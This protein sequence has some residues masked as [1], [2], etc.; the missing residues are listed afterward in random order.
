VCRL[1]L[2]VNNQ[3]ARFLVSI[4]TS[5]S[6][7]NA[8][9]EKMQL[10]QFL[11]SV[12]MSMCRVAGRF[13]FIF[14]RQLTIFFIFCCL[15]NQDATDQSIVNLETSQNRQ[16]VMVGQAMTWDFLHWPATITLAQSQQCL[17][18]FFL[19]SFSGM[20]NSQ[21]ETYNMYCSDLF[22]DELEGTLPS[23][24]LS[25]TQLTWLALGRNR[26]EGSVPP[27]PSSL[28]TLYLGDNR[29]SGQLPSLP[30]R[31][32][33]LRCANNALLGT[34]PPLP[35][36]LTDL[37]LHNNR[38]VGALHWATSPPSFDQWYS[39]CHTC[40]ATFCAVM[41]NSRFCSFLYN[42]TGNCFV[43]RAHDSNRLASGNA[44]DNCINRPMQ[45]VRHVPL[46]A[47]DRRAARLATS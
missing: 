42:T 44:Y 6:G 15:S 43:R 11:E 16:H 40:R 47:T 37:W 17:Y 4:L 39:R 24:L 1:F 25:F 29:F 23:T 9:F 7:V 19:L 28:V 22:F 35:A 2:L 41:S 20:E 34:V 27:L 5:F 10:I 32:A 46:R 33:L 45:R 8:L 13:Y 14:V 3:N 30:P 12:G 38:F 36:T 18:C 21:T 31:L 26:L